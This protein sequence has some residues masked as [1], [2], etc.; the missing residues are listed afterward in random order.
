MPI[1]DHKMRLHGKICQ[2]GQQPVL[3]YVLRK[4]VKMSWLSMVE[5]E[6]IGLV[7]VQ[8]EELYQHCAEESKLEADKFVS[9][10]KGFILFYSGLFSLISH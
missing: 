7:N 4:N 9:F 3:L 1:A 8:M 10:Y 6:H 5:P 2:R